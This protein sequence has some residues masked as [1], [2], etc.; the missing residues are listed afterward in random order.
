MHETAV[1]CTFVA[2]A[3]LCPILAMSRTDGISVKEATR[4]AAASAFSPFRHP[5]FAVIWTATVVSNVGTWMYTAASGWLMTSLNPDPLTVSLVQVAASL[6]IFLIAI[7]AG[8]LADIVDRRKFLIFAETATTLASAIFA[9][10]VMLDLAT[11]TNLLVF[12]FLIGAFSALTAPAWQSVTPQLVPRQDLLPAIAI[13]SVGF[14]ISRAIGPALGGAITAA[15][16]VAAPFWVNAISNLGVIGGLAWWRSPQRGPSHLPA[17]RFGRAIRTGLRYARHNSYLRSTMLRAVGFFL[18]ASAYWA[19]L[20]LIA[21]NRI[22]AG[23][24]I[25]GFLLG[26]IGVGAVVGAFALPWAKARLGAD[27]LVAAG[28]LGTAVALVLFAMARDSVTALAAS[29]LAGVAWIAV[30]S[31]LNVS[32]QVALPEWVRARGLSLFMTVYFGAHTAGSALWGQVAA[33]W[34]LPIA[35][36]VAA[37]GALAV[38]PLTW[39]W[40][41]QGGAGVDLTPSGHWPEPVVD[42]AVERD[43]GPVMVMVE[44]RIDPGQ[45]APFLAVLDRLSDERRRDGAYAWGV[46]EDTAE[47]GHI[48]ETFLVESWLEHLRQHQRVTNADRVIENEIYGYHIEGAPK[49]THMIA[50]DRE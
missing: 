34:G 37:A 7:P 43:R 45:R 5:A 14:N 24:E 8:A 30:L 4:M 15:F 6:P 41:L 25:Y 21:R 38:I 23:P 29:L 44:Y 35:L 13:N 20:P 22:A 49:V 17:E 3:R 36:F 39:R 33:Q 18:F 42:I 1:K 32:A 27:R 19:L 50:P 26:A 16:G 10:V 12:T 2:T 11:P 47:P 48:V 46:F 9:L 40:H 31:T 28:T